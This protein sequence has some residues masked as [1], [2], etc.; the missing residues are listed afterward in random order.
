MVRRAGHW[1]WSA[2]SL[3]P[4]LLP[5]YCQAHD[6]VHLKQLRWGDGKEDPFWPAVLVVSRG[7]MPCCW[8]YTI[9]ELEVGHPLSSPLCHFLCCNCSGTRTVTC[10]VRL[11]LSLSSLLLPSLYPDGKMY[12]AARQ[13]DKPCGK[14]CLVTKC[15]NLKPCY[16]V[17]VWRIFLRWCYY[18]SIL[19]KVLLPYKNKSKNMLLREGVEE[20]LYWTNCR[21]YSTAQ[22]FLV[23][24]RSIC[25]CN[26]FA[27]TRGKKLEACSFYTC[28]LSHSFIPSYT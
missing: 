25:H 16:Y 17:L 6:T 8:R 13:K 23:Y 26:C 2:W 12:Q 28:T 27:N 21:T 9:V 15:A 11:N 3:L 22:W 5:P 1:E 4:F 19:S 14:N 10:V 20:V 18:L 7:V 24:L